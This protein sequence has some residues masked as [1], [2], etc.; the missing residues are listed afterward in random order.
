M[1]EHPPSTPVPARIP[2]QP[3][4]TPGLSQT[5]V[6]P[7]PVPSFKK[8]LDADMVTP[9]TPIKKV[10]EDDISDHS[11]PPETEHPPPE[12]LLSTARSEEQ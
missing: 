8:T 7:S 3:S 11:G 12:Y 2:V 9:A 5:P 1:P 4:H 6:P 10:P